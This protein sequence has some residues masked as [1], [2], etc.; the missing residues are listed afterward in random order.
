MINGMPFLM[1]YLDQDKNCRETSHM[2]SFKALLS[3][4]NCEIEHFRAANLQVNQRHK[5]CEAL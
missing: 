3:A 2:L 4:I 5:P 1:F